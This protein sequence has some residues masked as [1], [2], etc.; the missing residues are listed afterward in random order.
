MPGLAVGNIMNDNNPSQKTESA[1]TSVSRRELFHIISSAPALAA[2]TAGSGLAQTHTHSGHDD[3]PAAKGPYQ[4]KVFNDHQWHTVHVLCDLIMPADER[5][6][7]ATQ[8]AVP[9]FIDDWLDFRK[10]EDGDEN[11]AAQILGGLSWLD[12]ESNRLFAK[13]FA[14][15]ALPEQKQI[16]D[17]VAWPERAAAA[18]H[19]WVM[20]FNKFR[21]LTVSGFFSSKMGIADLPY[22]GNQAIAEWKGCDPAVWAKVE[23]RMRTGYKGLGGEAPPWSD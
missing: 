3:T 21:D 2:A 11:F 7:S 16:L 12:H 13:D 6:G 18:D 17:R 19:P 8:A 10:H 20:F 4:R 22:L 15:A 23:E 1:A 14:D 9:E 5:S